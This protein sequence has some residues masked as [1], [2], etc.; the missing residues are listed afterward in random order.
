MKFLDVGSTKYKFV[1][2]NFQSWCILQPETAGNKTTLITKLVIK[3]ACAETHHTKTHIQNCQAL[4]EQAASRSLF[5]VQN[6]IPG[7]GTLKYEITKCKTESVGILKPDNTKNKTTEFT[8][9]AMC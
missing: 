6:N 5:F 2:C 3:L 9:P 7:C 8:K 4:S 1:K